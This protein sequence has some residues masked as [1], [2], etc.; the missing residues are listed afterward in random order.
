MQKLALLANG[1]AQECRGERISPVGRNPRC[2]SVL[3]AKDHVAL[4]KPSRI[5]N[6][7]RE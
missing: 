1:L 3:D 7:D 5:L 2:L 4:K 6:E